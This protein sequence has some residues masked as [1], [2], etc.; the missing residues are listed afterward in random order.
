[1]QKRMVVTAIATLS[2]TGLVMADSEIITLDGLASNDLQ[3]EATNDT[4]DLGL[5]VGDIIE[6]V[7]FDVIMTGVG[8]SWFEEATYSLWD[9]AVGGSLIADGSEGALS[10][11]PGSQDSEFVDATAT[12]THDISDYVMTTGTLVVELHEWNFDDNPG[13]PDAFYEDGSSLAINYIAVPG[14][15]SL[16]LLGLAGLL[17]HRRRR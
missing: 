15:A 11:S 8:F 2:L 5:N 10:Y 13:G 4:V 3:G 12:G 17:G 1:M 9:G 7:D 16:A 6:S 14:P